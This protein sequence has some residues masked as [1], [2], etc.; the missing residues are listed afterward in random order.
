M[1]NYHFDGEGQLIDPTDEKTI[2]KEYN[3]K[4]PLTFVILMGCVL[5]GLLVLCGVCYAVAT[6]ILNML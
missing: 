4:K 5:V 2:I 1:D 3:D 6:I